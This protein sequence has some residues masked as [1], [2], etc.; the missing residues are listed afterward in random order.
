MCR[1]RTAEQLAAT[2]HY[3]VGIERA[4]RNLALDSVDVLAAHPVVD[5]V[6]LL[7][8]GRWSLGDDDVVIVVEVSSIYL[9][10][11]IR[12]P[13][14]SLAPK[15]SDKITTLTPISTATPM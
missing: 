3:V 1:P 14:P 5:A 6:S 13:T 15:S 9:A 12:A 11:A 7:D 2:P 8:A 10:S 4:E